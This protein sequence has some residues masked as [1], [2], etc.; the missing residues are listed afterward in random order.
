MTECMTEHARRDY[1]LAVVGSGAMLGEVHSFSAMLN[2]IAVEKMKGRRA[3]W[4][5]LSGKFTLETH[6]EPDLERILLAEQ[7]RERR[8][9]RRLTRGY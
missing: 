1:R 9:Q 8:K 2:E 6:L 5:P 4:P 7:K 3:G